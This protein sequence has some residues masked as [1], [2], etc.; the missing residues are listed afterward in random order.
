M[1]DTEQVKDPVSSYNKT[2]RFGFLLV[3]TAAYALF[4]C[5]QNITRL[6]VY[7]AQSEKAAK[8]SSTAAER[9]R[10]T[11]TTQAGATIAILLSLVSSTLL[12]IPSLQAYRLPVGI[13]NAVLLAASRYHFGNF[14][15]AKNQ[16]QVPFVE[17]FNEAVRGSEDVRKM[18]G[19]LAWAWSLITFDWAIGKGTGLE[20]VG[21]AILAVV[22]LRGW[23]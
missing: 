22:A 16:V 13:T 21:T 19:I 17:K 15:N 14:W 23:Y 7:E 8:W 2:R 4:L 5:Y 6:R 10:K 12:Y 9:L 18:L 1:A 11:R 3:P 20:Y